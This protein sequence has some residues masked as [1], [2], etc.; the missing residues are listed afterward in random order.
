MHST[1]PKRHSSRASAPAEPGRVAESG[2]SQASRGIDCVGCG[3][4]KRRWW[5]DRRPNANHPSTF[6]LVSVRQPGWLREP[7]GFAA[8]SRDGCAIS[9]RPTVHDG[10]PHVQKN[11][12]PLARPNLVVNRTFAHAEKVP[13]GWALLA[14][15]IPIGRWAHNRVGIIVRH[16][17]AGQRCPMESLWS[18][19]H[20]R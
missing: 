3:R 4:A 12:R 8:P 10:P 13:F 7:R 6:D 9:W 18:S 20:R 17:I 19:R 5:V 2:M 14:H 16:R 1:N 15:A 11:R